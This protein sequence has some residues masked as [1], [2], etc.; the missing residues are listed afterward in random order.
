MWQ[1]RCQIIPGEANGGEKLLAPIYRHHT[2]LPS[3]SEKGLHK[4]CWKQAPA[5]PPTPHPPIARGAQ[6]YGNDQMAQQCKV[7]DQ[8]VQRAINRGVSVEAR[9]LTFP[10]P[11]L[12]LLLVT[13]PYLCV[14]SICHSDNNGLRPESS[15]AVA[16]LGFTP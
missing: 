12:S 14:T 4:L 11:G 8:A 10:T 5:P 7:P 16:C 6:S 9:P 2:S 1:L 15:S 3:P 13:P